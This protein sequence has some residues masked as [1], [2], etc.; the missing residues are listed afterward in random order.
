MKSINYALYTILKPSITDLKTNMITVSSPAIDSDCHSEKVIGN[1]SDWEFSRA[2]LLAFQSEK[3]RVGD[4][5]F[6]ALFFLCLFLLV[7]II[8]NYHKLNFFL[9]NKVSK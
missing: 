5:G 4:C 2:K 1:E 6:P 8:A 3:V 7:S 9:V